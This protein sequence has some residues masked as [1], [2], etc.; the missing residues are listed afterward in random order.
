M[1]VITFSTMQRFEG[2]DV[3]FLKGRRE[4]AFLLLYRNIVGLTQVRK[5]V[6]IF[7]AALNG[8]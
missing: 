6:L 7:N 2:R 8:G 5:K 1:V 3:T 4:T